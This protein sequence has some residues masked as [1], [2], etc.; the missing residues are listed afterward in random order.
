M[1]N[2]KWQIVWLLPLIWLSLFSGE[3]VGAQSVSYQTYK[4]GTSENSMASGYY[5]RPAKVTVQN[6]QYLVTM[7]IKTK[8]ALTAWP[9]TVLSVAGQ[10][11]SNVKKTKDS[12]FY[13]YAYSFYSQDL[14]KAVSSKIKIDVP[15]TYQATHQISFKFDQASLPSLKKTSASQKTASQNSTS[16]EKTSQASQASQTNNSSSDAAVAKQVLDLEKEVKAKEKKLDKKEDTL[17]ARAQSLNQRSQAVNA[18]SQRN[19]FFLLFG[20]ILVLSLFILDILGLIYLMR[21]SKQQKEH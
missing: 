6:G 20:G 12:N 19:F 18:A 4:Y 11:P 8:K 7:T 14:S 13:Y 16:K 17:A 5:A 9:V 10:S 15:G 1:T 2:K 21:K 3:K